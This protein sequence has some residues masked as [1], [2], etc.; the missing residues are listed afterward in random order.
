MPLANELLPARNGLVDFRTLEILPPT[1]RFFSTFAVPLD[2]DPEAPDPATW[3]WFLGSIWGDDPASIRELRK[4]FAYVLSLDKSQEKLLFLKG[5]RRSGKGTILRVIEA[6]VG[7]AAAHSTNLKAL[8]SRFGLW[9]L[10]DKA[11]AIIP[12]ARFGSAGENSD[13]MVERLLSITSRD[14]VEVEGKYLKQQS[15]KIPARLMICTNEVP[16]LCERS[17]A[18]AGRFHPLALTRSFFGREDLTLADRIIAGELSGVLKWA[19]RGR[20][21]LRQDGKF[22]IPVTAGPI[23]EKLSKLTNPVVAF[24]E[25]CCELGEGFITPKEDLH[26]SYQGWCTAR[27]REAASDAS[28]F[29]NLH[30]S[31]DGLEESRPRKESGRIRLIKGIRLVDEGETFR[32]RTRRKLEGMKP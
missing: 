18:L 24:V 26:F 2:F 8:G 4:W 12:D 17:G 32:Q 31:H 6:L 3:L 10:L 20:E 23:V 14:T 25:E 7:R 19:I 9:P 5:P 11:L 15:V 22:L 1:P 27:R 30:A 29:R 28:F 16:K 21:A 13:V